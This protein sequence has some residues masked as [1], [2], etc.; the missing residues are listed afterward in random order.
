MTE[1]A[2][3]WAMSLTAKLHPD[4]FT[5]MSPKMTAIIAYVLGEE[6]TDP[7]IAWMSVSSDGYVTTDADFL[8]D[9]A[10]L[11]R[12]IRKLLIAAGLCPTSARSSRGCS[13]NA[14][15]IT[16][17]PRADPT[18]PS[19]SIRTGGKRPVSGE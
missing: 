18:T 17:R 1:S 2:Y 16:A 13:A 14:S 5:E 15:T 6:W 8:G 19:C 12:N 10:D 9:A 11:D 7:Q 4:R 3:D